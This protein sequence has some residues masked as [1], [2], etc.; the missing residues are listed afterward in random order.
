[1]GLNIVDINVF[2]FNVYKRFFLNFCHVFNVFN[3][4]LQLCHLS[5]S[6]NVV[7]CTEIRLKLHYSD[8][9]WICWTRSRTSCTDI[10]D[11]F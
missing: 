7:A 11:L 10:E 6:L 9:V 2:L 3:V 4:F 5:L 1:M 8:L